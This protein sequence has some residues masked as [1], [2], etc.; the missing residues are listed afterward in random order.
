MYSHF[1]LI[2]KYLKYY[3][4]ASNGKG[5]GVHSPFV[6]DFIIN[7]L[8]DRTDYMCY[9]II[10]PLR[11]ELLKN[12]N[13]IEVED[14][15]AGSLVLPSRIKKIKSIAASSL[16]RQKYAQL[17][18]RITKYY[19]LKT[20]VE[21]GTSLGITTSY[22]ACAD[23][24]GFVYTMEG[25]KSIAALANETFIKNNLNNI[26]LIQGNFDNN[27]PVLINKLTKVDLLFIDG[28]HRMKPTLEYF[29]E[30]LKKAT[31]QSIFIFDD[32]HWSEEMEAAWNVIKQHK[33]VT[34]TIDLFFIG[35]VFFNTDFKEKQ[36]FTIRF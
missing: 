13:E 33:S 32:I 10:E 5:H 30:F 22:L 35:L 27:I 16:K 31:N 3:V 23:S 18:F 8:N 15:G 9:R 2:K 21:M 24:K 36:N 11:S 17:L 4:T 25:A 29:E 7:V 34:L 20:I 28:N 6:Y 1:E 12:D 26:E 19:Q 14:F